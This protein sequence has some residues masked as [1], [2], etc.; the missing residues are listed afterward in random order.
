[1]GRRK[2]QEL[3]VE[4]LKKY[5][6]KNKCYKIAVFGSL[7]K[8]KDN[9]IKWYN[10]TFDKELKYVDKILDKDIEIKENVKIPAKQAVIVVADFSKLSNQ[11]VYL[12]VSLLLNNNSLIAQ[13]IRF[14][15]VES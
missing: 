1:M 10:V 7:A 6:I 4:T 11:I 15:V 5:K 8:N 14:R 9:K 2:K 3:P 13:K 12:S